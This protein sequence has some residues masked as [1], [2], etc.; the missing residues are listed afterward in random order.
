MESS[1]Y[2]SLDV[3]RQNYRATRE[4]FYE[5]VPHLKQSSQANK[6]Y[7]TLCKKIPQ[8]LMLTRFYR[9]RIIVEFCKRV[10]LFLAYFMYRLNGSCMVFLYRLGHSVEII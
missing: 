4:F 2:I 8:T 5:N 6:N 1:R 9:I 7:G 3:S 10:V